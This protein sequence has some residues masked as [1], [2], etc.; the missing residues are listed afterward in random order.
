MSSMQISNYDRIT[1][2][3]RQKNIASDAAL[4]E[5]L[6][7]QSILLAYHSGKLENENITFHDTREIFEHDGG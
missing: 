1:E 4:A 2:Y 7:G 5:I 3:W 6:N